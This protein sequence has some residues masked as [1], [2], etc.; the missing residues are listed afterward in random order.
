[1]NFRAKGESSALFLVKAWRGLKR[2]SCLLTV[3]FSRN[4]LSFFI[5]LLTK[6]LTGSRKF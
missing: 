5:I 4:Y 6:D 3:W 2:V 1:M